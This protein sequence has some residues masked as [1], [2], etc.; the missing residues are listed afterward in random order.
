MKAFFTSLLLLGGLSM[1]SIA[2]QKTKADSRAQCLQRCLAQYQDNLD[3]CEDSCFV[4]DFWLLFCV[5]G[6]T[7]EA[8]RE[9]CN[10]GAQEVW[11]A[12]KAECP[13][14]PETLP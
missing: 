8:C 7:D 6:H 11:E 4:C 12:C 13:P 3:D 9:T 5:A 14:P 10:A 2:A 1:G